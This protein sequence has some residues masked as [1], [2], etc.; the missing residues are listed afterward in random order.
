[1]AEQLLEADDV[2]VVLVVAVEAVGAASRLEQVV[3][4]Q[5]VIEIDVGAARRVEAGVFQVE[6]D[7]VGD[8][9]VKLVGVDA[10]P[11]LISPPRCTSSRP[12]PTP[13][14][15]TRFTKGSPTPSSSI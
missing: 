5:L 6:D 14:T 15:P 11:P 4:A 8:P 10:T 2:A 13:S 3:I 12:P 9:F 7:A 1:V